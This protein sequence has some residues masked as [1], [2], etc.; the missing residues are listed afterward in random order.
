MAEE[1]PAGPGRVRVTVASGTRRADVALPG[2]VDV[3]ELVPELARTLGLL[4]AATVHG[5][6][7]L[8]T[9]AGRTLAT[10]TGLVSQGVEDGAVLVVAPDVDDVPPRRHDDVAEAMAE[11]V[12]LD[13][14]RWDAA[15]G[16]RMSHWVALLLLLTGTGAPLTQPGSDGAAIG[17][18]AMAVG[19][20][21]GAVGLSRLRG[22][23]AVAVGVAWIGCA[24]AAVA[25]LLLPGDTSAIG[26]PVAAAGGGAVVAGL[27]ATLGLREH[28]TL[29]LPP[30]LVGAV[31]L[32]AGLAARA[33]ASDPAVVLTA[34][35]A[36]VV[37]AG[38]GV[39]RVALGAAGAHAD[40]PVHE[41]TGIDLA[42]LRADARLAR[43]IVVAVSLAVGL[44]LVLVAPVAVS[45]GPAGA[46]VA[47]LSCGV[48]MLRSRRHLP[49]AEVVLGLASGVL[50][51]FSVALSS[52]WL[53]PDWRP[54]VSVAL[55]VTG[56]ALLGLG[57]GPAREGTS[58][59]LGRV[60]DILEGAALA[61]LLPTLVLASGAVT[62][63]A[64]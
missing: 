40:V 43:E 64:D 3:A 26:T 25:G 16:R 11:L 22:D 2:G 12:E 27:A 54:E 59:R 20:T 51:L 30:V 56:V 37:V 5:G 29:L 18:L 49:A 21:A 45:L 35:V 48:T 23:V 55:V 61:A 57:L 60:A 9:L 34:A 50:G 1:P 14:A 58:P 32:T 46:L 24:Y 28:R 47:V 38:S 33:S 31:L 63:L 7:R 19:L 10:G 44:L 36:L 6:Y 62:A 17:A 41:V 8:V 53:Q 4:D 15:T 13:T 52:L 39:P 42:R